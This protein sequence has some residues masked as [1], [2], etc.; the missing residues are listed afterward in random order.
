MLNAFWDV[1]SHI[2]LCLSLPN[3]G[4]SVISFRKIFIFLPHLPFSFP[5][6]HSIATSFS[7]SALTFSSLSPLN[8]YN[9]VTLLFLRLPVHLDAPISLPS[10][11]PLCH[12]IGELSEEKPILTS[13]ASLSICLHPIYTAS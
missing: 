3:C 5:Y 7:L 10:I 13:N 12:Q 6:C 4:L 11:P 8:I 1:N 2:W 9:L